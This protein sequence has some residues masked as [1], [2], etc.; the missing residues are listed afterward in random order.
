M[1]NF[2]EYSSN[3]TLIGL[4]GPQQQFHCRSWQGLDAALSGGLVIKVISASDA[5]WLLTRRGPWEKDDT[6]R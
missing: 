2:P 4:A 3:E 6:D 5:F 1:V